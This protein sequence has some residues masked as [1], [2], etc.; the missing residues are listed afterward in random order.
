MDSCFFIFSFIVYGYCELKKFHKN[1]Y[2]YIIYKICS[3]IMELNK[4]K[5]FKGIE[6]IIEKYEKSLKNILI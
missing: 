1:K 3:K 4:E 2:G 6:P 5:Y